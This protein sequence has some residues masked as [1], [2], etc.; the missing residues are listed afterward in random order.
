MSA[1]IMSTFPPRLRWNRANRDSTPRERFMGASISESSSILGAVRTRKGGI[2]PRPS[3]SRLAQCLASREQVADRRGVSVFGGHDDEGVALC[4][5]RQTGG[6]AYAGNAGGNAAGRY[7][8][9]YLR[10]IASVG[11]RQAGHRG[12]K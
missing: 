1:A 11:A 8:V 9:P 4:G 6:K 12:G 2:D 3:E 10:P 7:V 5:G